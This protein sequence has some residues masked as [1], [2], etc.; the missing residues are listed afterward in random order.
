MLLAGV[1]ARAVTPTL[2]QRQRDGEDRLRAPTVT[3]A[4]TRKDKEGAIGAAMKV[5]DVKFRDAR[6]YNY[7]H[8]PTPSPPEAIWVGQ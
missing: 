4:R 7:E 6:N 2:I 3:W 8:D 1:A 5:E